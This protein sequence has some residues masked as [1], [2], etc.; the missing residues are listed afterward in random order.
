MSIEDM[1][2]FHFWRAHDL[3]TDG[4]PKEALSHIEAALEIEPK[5]VQ[6]MILAGD[7]Y[8]LDCEELGIDPDKA[9]QIAIQC[10]DRAL[11]VDPKLAE[12][13][14]GK[15]EVL[16]WSRCPELALESAETGLFL[17]PLCI[18]Y[19]MNS[20]DVHINVAE[21]LFKYKVS[22]LLRLGRKDEARQALSDG[23]EYCPGS[24]YLS[25]LLEE[26]VPEIS[27]EF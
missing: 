9:F 19:A 1:A 18:G 7:I 20:P 14:A 26:F 6:A 8:Q 24:E 3:S 17:L 12:A 21:T 22:A 25:G 23:L 11:A 15:A 13:W 2:D 4:R 5:H 27:K 16:Y 10:Y